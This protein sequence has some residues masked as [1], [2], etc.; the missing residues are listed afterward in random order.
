[1]KLAL[2]R[3]SACL[4]V[5]ALGLLS[6]QAQTRVGIIDLQKVFD[7]YF[8]TKQADA[9]LKE[10]GADFRK[11]LDGMLEEYKK[12]NQDYTRLLD[13]AN[14]QAVSTEEREKRKKSAE[15]KLLEIKEIETQVNQFRRSSEQTILEQQRR[16]RDNIVREIREVISAKAKA[17]GYSMVV[18]TAGLT[19][20]QTPVLLYT[21]GE[22]D[23]TEEVLKAINTNAPADLPKSDPKEKSEDP[24]PEK[25]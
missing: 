19:V 21:N 20:N 2:I 8:K 23:L 24:K 12:A 9:T 5:V 15:T 17:A 25:K 3:F 4:F 16:M 18:D 1:M 22:N 11:S 14:D 6:A 13:S 7:G 10:R